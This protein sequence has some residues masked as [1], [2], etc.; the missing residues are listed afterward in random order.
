MAELSKQDVRE[1]VTEVVADAI[2]NLPTSTEMHSEIDRAIESLAQVTA[3]GFSA[4]DRRFD[5]IDRDYSEMKYLLTDVVRRDEFMNLKT[6]V[7]Q[8]ELRVST[9]E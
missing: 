5:R 6:R 7:D 9:Q 4:V 1:I 3:Q 8:L 2:K